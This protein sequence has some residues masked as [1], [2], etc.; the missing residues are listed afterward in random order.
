MTRRGFR[1]WPRFLIR[2]RASVA[3]PVAG[4]LT[5]GFL[6]AAAGVIVI[7]VGYVIDLTAA[8]FVYDV[9]AF[10]MLAAVFGGVAGLL[11]GTL[12]GFTAVAART[13]ARRTT[14]TVRARTA[15]TAA[16]TVTGVAAFV[17]AL[18]LEAPLTQSALIAAPTAFTTAVVVSHLQHTRRTAGTPELTSEVAGR[19]TR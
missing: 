3:Y 1:C 19:M 2:A 17:G 4:C 10:T 11:V 15:T 5:G 9:V 18:L 7:L 12:A 6:G 16:A 14:A 8:T 13:V